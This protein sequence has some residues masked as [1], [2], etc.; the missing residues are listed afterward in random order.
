MTTQIRSK[1]FETNSSSS[2]SITVSGT[3]AADFGLGRE[4]LRSGAIQIECHSDFGWKSEEHHGTTDKIAY[5]LMQC[6]PNHFNDGVEYDEDIIPSLV[7]RNENARWLVDVIQRTTGCTLEFRA[8]SWA[9]IDHQSH[10]EGSEMFTD[11]AE[12]RR[13]LFS[14]SSYLQTGNDNDDPYDY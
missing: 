9:G 5:M 12:M 3:E 8:G 6:D 7:E 2:H 13:F 11:E 1:V 10:G 14:P 4:T